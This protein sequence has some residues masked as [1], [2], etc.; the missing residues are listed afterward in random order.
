MSYLNELYVFVNGFYKRGKCIMPWWVLN[1]LVEN[2]V[3]FV[4][5]PP[6]YDLTLT[7][8]RSD[9]TL[10]V[11]NNS[12]QFESSF[13]DNK[14]RVSAD[15][16]SLYPRLKHFEYGKRILVNRYVISIEDSPS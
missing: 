7:L 3:G 11:Y 9:K 15:N 16:I 14:G 13:S 2:V 1:Y 12:R 4:T 10:L 5:M 8:I 6:L